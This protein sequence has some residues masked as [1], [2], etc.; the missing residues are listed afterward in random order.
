[1]RKNLVAALVTISL[2]AAA[3]TAIIVTNASAQ[4]PA[5]GPRNPVLLAQNA[6]AR[7]PARTLNRPAPM[8]AERSERRNAMCQ[9]VYARTA[10][11]FAALEVR[12][13]LTGAQVP[14]FAR[15]RDL[16][17]AAA[18]SRA[19]ECAARPLPQPGAGRGPNATP[20]SPVE[21]LTREETQLQ[22]RLADIQ[23]ERPALEALYTS[24]SATQRQTQAR[25]TRAGA[26]RSGRGGF[27]RPGFGGPR[28]GMMMRRGGPM[29]GP[30]PMGRP[31]NGRGNPPPPPP[32]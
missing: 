2:G 28:G 29:R 15:W 19:S 9:E 21:R 13:G 8:A 26:G 3:A 4:A 10:G 16:R 30:A 18:K 14:A 17:L 7:G 31:M 22:H 5:P 23:A 27:G 11:R 32:Q 20:P 25:E 24:L 12:L 1:M 6:P